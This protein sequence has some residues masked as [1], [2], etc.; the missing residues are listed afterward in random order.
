MCRIFWKLLELSYL[1]NKRDLNILNQKDLILKYKK[2][3]RFLGA[4]DYS[5]STLEGEPI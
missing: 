1:E 4:Q 3:K 5:C 2:H